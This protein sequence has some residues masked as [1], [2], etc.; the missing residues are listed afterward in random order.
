MPETKTTAIQFRCSSTPDREATS[1]N[2][3]LYS[4]HY[5]QGECVKRALT[6]FGICWAAAGVTLF[7]PLAHFILV[8]GFLIA[9]PVVG[10][11][12]YKADKIPERAD[13]PCP[14]CKKDISI[15]METKDRIPKW[16]YC[17]DCNASLH[18]DN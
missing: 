5:S 12:T 14:N 1:T 15:K 13:G 10:Y 17:P 9:G 3:T 4:T 8:P 11:L 2:A 16:T 18:I 6:R 7:I